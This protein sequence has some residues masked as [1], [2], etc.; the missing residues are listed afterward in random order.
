MRALYSLLRDFGHH[1][2][3]VLLHRLELRAVGLEPF[4]ARKSQLEAQ[5]LR[6]LE[7]GVGHVVAVADP[8]DALPFPGAEVLLDGEDVR[9]HLARVSE[10]REAVDHRDRREAR[11]LLDLGMVERADHDPVDVAGKHAGGI[12]DWLTTADLDVLA[13]EEQGLAAQLVGAD[14]KGNAGAGRGLGE[15]HRQRLAGE[16]GFPVP[17][18]LHARGEL[19]KLLDLLA[20]EVRDLQEVALRHRPPSQSK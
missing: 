4:G 16:G 7:P 17:P 6:S 10:V 9:H 12:R 20:A 5:D 19:E 18:R 15:D 11:Q 1:H 14:L 2:A 13:G 3:P 8:G